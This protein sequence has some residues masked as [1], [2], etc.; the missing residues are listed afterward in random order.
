MP[1]VD[2]YYDA[3][4]RLRRNKPVLVK[5]GS[6]INKDTVALEAGRKRGSIRNRPEFSQLIA[7]IEK[8]VSYTHLTLPTS[9][10]V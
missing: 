7:D 1:A 5:K 3:L 4:N 8:A 2:Y 9:D 6:A 10:L